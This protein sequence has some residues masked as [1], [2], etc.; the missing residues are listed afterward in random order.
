[1]TNEQT[2]IIAAQITKLIGPRVTQK[3]I[4]DFIWQ[5]RAPSFDKVAYNDIV[6]GLSAHDHIRLVVAFAVRSRGMQ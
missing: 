1:M 5:M 3:E 2:K 6:R 4:D